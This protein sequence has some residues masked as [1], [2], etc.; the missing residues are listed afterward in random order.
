MQCHTFLVGTVECSYEHG[1]AEF[2]KLI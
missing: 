2:C 1:C